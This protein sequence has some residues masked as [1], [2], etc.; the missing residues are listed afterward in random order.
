MKN[1]LLPILL[2]IISQ[3]IF[4]QTAKDKGLSA[5]D[6]NKAKEYIEVLAGDSLEGRKAGASGGLKASE[7][8]KS[9][10]LEMG[11]KPW[12]D[13]YFQ[14]FENENHKSLKMRNVLG[15]IP[16]KYIDEVVVIGA[17][18]DHLGI[19][20]NKTNDSIYNGADDNASGVSAIL[21]IAGAFM[22]SGEKPLRTV[23]FALWDGEEVGLLGSFHF[24]ED[25]QENITFPLLSAPKMKGHI[26]CDMIGR[27][28]T[29]ADY[30]HV[31]CFFSP[32]KPVFKEWLENDIV[33]YHLDLAPEFHPMND[34]P[35]GSD[36]L[37]FSMK[38]IP[39]M[40]YNTDLH[41]D[42][43][44]PSDHADKINYDKVVN[45]TKAAY[46]NLW[47]MANLKDF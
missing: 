37:P 16:G 39:V 14:P 27:N 36:H 8:I 18:Y 7:Y 12:V 19:K 10:F 45:I 46:L 3:A 4:A 13:N 15:Y 47:N 38:G 44:Q 25:F 34:S 24:V 17:H 33:R 42:Y 35:G 23:I 41:E 32:E 40:F 22:A 31:A 21:Q 2:L 43:H 1:F 11:I 26:N 30:N 28:K 9:K 6:L 5:I 20:T 29:E